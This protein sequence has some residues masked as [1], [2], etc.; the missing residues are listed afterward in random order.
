MSSIPGQVVL[1]S[2]EQDL[3]NQTRQSRCRPTA[4]RTPLPRRIVA[5][6]GD[7]SSR[8]RSPDDNF[9]C[10]ECSDADEAESIADHYRSIIAKIKKQQVEQS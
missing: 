7:L 5:Q 9:V 1:S 6:H 10:E 4:R 2:C 3:R 8:W